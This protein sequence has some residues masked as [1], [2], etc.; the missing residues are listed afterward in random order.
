M[1]LREAC[2]VQCQEADAAGE[3]GWRNFSG[4]ILTRELKLLRLVTLPGTPLALEPFT[5]M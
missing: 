2:Q 1:H 3:E 5:E 4:H